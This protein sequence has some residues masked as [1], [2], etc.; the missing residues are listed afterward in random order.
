MTLTAYQKNFI[1]ENFFNAEKYNGWRSIATKL[2]ETGECVVGNNQP[3]WVGGVGNFITTETADGFIDCLRYKFNLS[4]FLQW[5]H[6]KQVR[7]EYINNLVE[8]KHQIEREI[9]ELSN[10]WTTSFGN[11]EK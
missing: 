11:T 8:E 6:F 1:I 3:I 5:E 2:L 7:C 4:E 9:N 10:L